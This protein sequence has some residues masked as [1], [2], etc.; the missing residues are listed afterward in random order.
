MFEYLQRKSNVNLFCMCISFG[1]IIL[2]VN[3]ALILRRRNHVVEFLVEGAIDT[4][5]EELSVEEERLKGFCESER[6]KMMQIHSI[7]TPHLYG[8][9]F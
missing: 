7:Y 1:Y 9:G 6:H 4:W 8:Q 3:N 5:L 2:V